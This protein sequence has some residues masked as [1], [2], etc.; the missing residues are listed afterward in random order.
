MCRQAV[1]CACLVGARNVYHVS[2][3]RVHGNIVS[4]EQILF[5]HAK[6]YEKHYECDAC[7]FSVLETYACVRYSAQAIIKEL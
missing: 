3:V 6:N 4:V 2:R 7:T 1:L 5:T